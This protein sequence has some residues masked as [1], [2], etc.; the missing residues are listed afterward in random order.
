[1]FSFS[2]KGILL[3]GVWFR[4]FEIV[5]LVMVA[6]SIM[7]IARRRGGRAPLWGAAAFIG[8][9]AVKIAAVKAGLFA[10]SIDDENGAIFQHMLAVAWLAATWLAARFL[11]G[12]SR[13]KAGRK[14]SCPSCSF[15]NQEDAV[16]CEACGKVYKDPEEK[17]GLSL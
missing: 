8:Y 6:G 5:L 17:G 12:R 15:L 11:L 9:L 4:V 10:G 13:V 14:W 1:M 7:T 2:F 3:F 16:V